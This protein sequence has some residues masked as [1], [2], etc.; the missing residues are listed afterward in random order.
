MSRQIYTA[1]ARYPLVARPHRSGTLSI[2]QADVPM[3]LSVDH[4]ACGPGSV[5]KVSSRI[6]VGSPQSDGI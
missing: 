1:S 3:A 4:L 5:P 2:F 6:S